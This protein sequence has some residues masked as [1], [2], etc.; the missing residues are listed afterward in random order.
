MM[1]SLPAWGAQWTALPLPAPGDGD[2][3]E[4]AG[5]VYVAGRDQGRPVLNRLDNRTWQASAVPLP[6][7]T[8][9]FCALDDGS[10]LLFSRDQI[11]LGGD[12]PRLLGRFPSLWRGLAPRDLNKVGWC[13]G[14]RLFLPDFDQLRVYSLVQGQLKLDAG[15]PVSA[16]MSLN[17]GAPSYRGKSLYLADIDLDGTADLLV[18]DD[19]LYYFRGK[20]AGFEPEPLRFAPALELTPLARRAVRLNDGEDFAKLRIRTLEAVTDLDGDGLADL[21]VSSLRTKSLLDQEVVFEIHFGRRTDSGLGF[22]VAPDATFKTQGVVFSLRR[23]DVDGD[24]RIDFFTPAVRLGLGKVVSALLT[25][26]VSVDLRLERQTPQRRLQAAGKGVTADMKVSIGSGEFRIPLMAAARLE[27]RQASFVVQSDEDEV[28]L[29]GLEGDRLKRLQ[30]LKLPLPKDG[31]RWL[32]G[33]GWLLLLPG[34]QDQVRDRLLLIQAKAQ[35]S[36]QP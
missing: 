26:S 19:G 1:L 25:G 35:A 15:L 16:F 3:Q 7:D 32:A 27:G 14:N 12:Q 11:W 2:W 22:T 20:G 10:L 30:R 36:S 29:Y 9:R 24:G 6:A 17:R 33:P 34:P 28:S 18:E 5:T 31:G 8:D 21:V 13:Q 23:Q 4:A